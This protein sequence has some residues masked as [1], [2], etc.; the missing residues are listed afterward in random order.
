MSSSPVP[1]KTRRVGQRCTLN[2]LRAETSFRWC[3]VV[4]R[5]G[6]SAQSLETL[7][8]PSP[9][10]RPCPGLAAIKKGRW[11]GTC[12]GP[13]PSES[14]EPELRMKISNIPGIIAVQT[15]GHFKMTLDDAGCHWEMEREAFLHPIS[16]LLLSPCVGGPA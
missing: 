1:L 13:K 14:V 15:C 10:E 12:S 7:H 16:R 5:R 2:L 11:H 9:I 6:V 8:Y 4:V 3:G